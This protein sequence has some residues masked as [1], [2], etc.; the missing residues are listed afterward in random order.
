MT[1]VDNGT[2]IDPLQDESVGNFDADAELSLDDPGENEGEGEAGQEEVEDPV[3]PTDCV[4]ILWGI[5]I[6]ECATGRIGSQLMALKVKRKLL[7]PER[8]GLMLCTLTYSLCMP[9]RVCSSFNYAF[10]PVT[11]MV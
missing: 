7:L 6:C 5:C 1:D 3:S 10:M 9:T 2:E 11:K 4:F 8:L